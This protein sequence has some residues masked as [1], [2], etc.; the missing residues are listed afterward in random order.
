MRCHALQFWSAA[1]AAFSASSPVL[2]QNNAPATPPTAPSTAPSVTTANAAA[3]ITRQELGPGNLPAD[4]VTINPKCAAVEVSVRLDIGVRVVCRDA[5]TT[6]IPFTSVVG[7]YVIVLN[8]QGSKVTI[9]T[10]DHT[11]LSFLVFGNHD[12]DS[13]PKPQISMDDS[14]FVGLTSLNALGFDNIIMEKRLQVTI[15]TGLDRLNFR[16][17]AFPA[18]PAALYERQYRNTL[19]INNLKLSPQENAQQLNATQYTN[20]LANLD[21]EQL[22][23]S[24]NVDFRGDCGDSVKTSSGRLANNR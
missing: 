7:G 8:R 15:P 19:K 14:S 21:T 23:E 22:A 5:G 3:T 24:S 11:N 4:Q 1:V 9:G 17:T 10:C 20:A 13:F 12:A 2:S 18:L 16:E 6:I